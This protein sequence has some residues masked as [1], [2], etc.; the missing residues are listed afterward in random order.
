MAEGTINKYLGID[1]G[2]LRYKLHSLRDPA[3]NSKRSHLKSH[4]PIEMNA[5]AMN[6]V[7]PHPTNNN[8]LKCVI[9]KRKIAFYQFALYRN[10]LM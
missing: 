2:A 6:L 3:L 1:G 4:F 8:K 7:Q 9:S 5:S 10:G